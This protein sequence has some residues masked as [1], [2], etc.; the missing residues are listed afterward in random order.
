VPNY[1]LKKVS[2]VNFLGF[3]FAFPLSDNITVTLKRGNGKWDFEQ[4]FKG[5]LRRKN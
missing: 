5:F 4:R 1:R 3:T 2:R